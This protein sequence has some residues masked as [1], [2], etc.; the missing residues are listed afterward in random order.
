MK[1]F[2]LEGVDYVGKKDSDLAPFSPF[3]HDAFMGCEQTDEAAWN[4]KAISRGIEVIP[5]PEGKNYIYTKSDYLK[6]LLE[7]IINA[8]FKENLGTTKKLWLRKEILAKL[9]NI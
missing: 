4:T 1:L 9:Q 2:K 3:Y 6:K 8:N 5:S 7:K